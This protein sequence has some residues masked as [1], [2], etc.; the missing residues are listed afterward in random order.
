MHGRISTAV[1]VTLFLSSLN[2]SGI[3]ATVNSAEPNKFFH[4]FTGPSLRQGERVRVPQEQHGDG[5]IDER[6]DGKDD[7]GPN[8][9]PQHV[10]RHG[11]DG[12]AGSL[13]LDGGTARSLANGHGLRN[14]SARHGT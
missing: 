8:V 1:L 11:W 13:D 10:H 12:Y 7:L 9:V 6:Q 4:E 3:P 14:C 5:A 2:G